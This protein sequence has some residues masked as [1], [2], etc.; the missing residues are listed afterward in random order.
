MDTNLPKYQ[1]HKTVQAFKIKQIILNPSSYSKNL[2][3]VD[4]SITIIPV[5][6]NIKPILVSGDYFLKHQPQM[7]GYYILYTDG[8]ESFSPAKAFEEG[9]SPIR[10]TTTIDSDTVPIDKKLLDRI[11]R[12]MTSSWNVNEAEYSELR[13]IEDVIGAGQISSDDNDKETG[14]Y[15]ITELRKLITQ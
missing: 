1:S 3:V 11:L 7:G 6:V 2:I 12:R 9:Y 14:L 13:N 4:S 10:N 5:D 15:E 8:Y